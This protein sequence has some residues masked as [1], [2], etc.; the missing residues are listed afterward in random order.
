MK[1]KIKLI[2]R[3]FKGAKLYFVTAIFAS[4]MMTLLNSLTPQIFKFTIDSVLGSEEYPFLKE[5][6]WVMAALIIATALFSGLFM[7]L[8]RY[9]TAKA[10]EN[11][12]ENMRNELPTNRYKKRVELALRQNFQVKFIRCIGIWLLVLLSFFLP[13]TS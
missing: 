4:L 7:F 3:F 10:G 6:L 1:R 5:N 12:A 2:T 11:F 13:V 9:H 8:S